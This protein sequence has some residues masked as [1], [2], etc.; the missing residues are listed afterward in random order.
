MEQ[1]DLQEKV[2]RQYEK[3]G[4]P[5]CRAGEIRKEMLPMPDGARLLTEICLPEG[6]ADEAFPVILMRSCYPSSREEREL[7]MKEYACRGFGFVL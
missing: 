4:K 5:I 2:R 7:V 1:M 6:L 3:T